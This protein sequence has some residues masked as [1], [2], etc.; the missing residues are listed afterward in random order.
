MRKRTVLVPCVL[1]AAACNGPEK[2]Y[3]PVLPINTDRTYD[4]RNPKAPGLDPILYMSI[5]DG[6]SYQERGL[7]I[8]ADGRIQDF[9]VLRTCDKRALRPYLS[10]CSYTAWRKAIKDGIF[11]DSEAI[12]PPK[13]N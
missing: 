8:P 2:H 9:A 5:F 1:V 4:E 3:A 10:P 13:K 12:L 6:C 11:Q 7:F